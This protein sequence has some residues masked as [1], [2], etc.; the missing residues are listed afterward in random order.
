M[1]ID[2]VAEAETLQAIADTGS[3]SA[4]A[5]RLGISQSS[6]SRRISALEERF[7]GRALVARTTRE[8]HLTDAGRVYL[9][10]SKA[11]L[12]QLYLAEK[13]LLE[14]EPEIQ[15]TL[16]LSLPPAIG[17]A[18]LLSPLDELL[19]EYPRL[20]VEVDFSERYVDFLQDGIDLAVRIRRTAQAGIEEE[21]IGQTRIVLLASAG[22]AK[23]LKLSRP[24]D[25]SRC[26]LIAPKDLHS[27]DFGRVLERLG[28]DREQ[29]QIYV[30][31]VSAVA[32]L[33]HDG[34]GVGFLPELVAGDALTK[35]TVVAIETG[36][37]SPL[38]KLYATYPRELKGTRRIGLL[39]SRFR[40]GLVQA[41]RPG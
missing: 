17:R 2:R 41:S 28:I 27:N 26:R 4:A 25:L 15:G 31:D 21:Q 36:Y 9:N 37:R 39:L 24:D 29:I 34:F 18:A 12:E 5:T 7:D 16:R 22:Y 13:Q 35:G 14:R 30:D 23:T 3:F 20:K 10:L 11:A 1:A 40:S 6:V 8:V 33:V 32:A 19:R 38:I